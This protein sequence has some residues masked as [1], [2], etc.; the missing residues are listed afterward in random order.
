LAIVEIH[1]PKCGSL[2]DLED[3]K[4]QKYSCSSCEAIFLFLEP[5][6]K[7]AEVDIE[8]HNC[9]ECGIWVKPDTEYTCSECEKTGL[10]CSCVSEKADKVTCKECLAKEERACDICGKEYLYRCAICGIKRCR[11]DYYSFNIEV[12]EYSR[13][14]DMKTGRYYSL[15]CPTCQGQ[16]CDK[17]YKKKEGFLRG[18]L[19]CYCKKCGD[20]LKMMAPHSSKT[21]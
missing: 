16:V 7:K 17:C 2:C 19:S 9:P 21:S 10:C 6:S 5:I 18:G 4:S 3:E 13:V 11:K 8:S 15:Y 20:K 14:L 1:C 12:R